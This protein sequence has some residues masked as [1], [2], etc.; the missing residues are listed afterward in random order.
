[1]KRRRTILLAAVLLVGALLLYGWSLVRRGFSAREEPSRLE[2]VLARGARS[3]AVPAG[4][5]RLQ[6]PQALTTDNLRDGMIHF[7]DHCAVCHGNDGGG[8]TDFGRNMYPRPPDLRAATQELPD[9]EIYFIIQHGVRLTGMPAFG[10]P[11]RTDDAG[12]WNLVHFIRY[13]PRLTEEEEAEMRR[14]NPVSRAELER[15]MAIERFLAGEGDEPA[16]E[17]DHKHQH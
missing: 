15:E 4:A 9:G 10:E 1:M 14:H 12:T 3:L 17:P 7:A 5:R 6:N 16:P 2:T 11:G 13:L 8:D